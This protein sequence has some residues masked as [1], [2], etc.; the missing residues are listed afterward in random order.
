M[1]VESK[2]LARL[3]RHEIEGT[4][5]ALSLTPMH[6]L[7]HMQASEVSTV[8]FRRRRRIFEILKSREMVIVYVRLS[9]GWMCGWEACVLHCKR[10]V[11]WNI[12]KNMITPPIF[13][14]GI[15]I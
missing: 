7:R 6:S 8:E 4:L 14:A 11:T 13:F 10:R 3:I 1:S 5:A 15:V 2:G 9:R 12:S